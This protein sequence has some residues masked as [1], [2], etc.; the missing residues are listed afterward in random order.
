MADAEQS[1]IGVFPICEFQTE[2]CALWPPITHRQAPERAALRPYAPILQPPSP[3]IEPPPPPPGTFRI[4]ANS[5]GHG[6]IDPVGAIDVDEGEDQLFTITADSGYHIANVVVDGVSVGTGD[7]YTF[8]DVTEDHTITASFAADTLVDLFPSGIY[9]MSDSVSALSNPNVNGFKAWMQWQQVNPAPG[10][11]RWDAFDAYADAAAAAGKEFEFSIRIC[12]HYPQW[13]AFTPGIVQYTLV[14]DPRAK[15]I[16][17]WDPVAQ[18]LILQFIEDLC[19]HYEGR[20]TCIVMGGMGYKTE[21]YMPDPTTTTPPIA[22]SIDDYAAEWLAAAELIV[23]TYAANLDRTRFIVAGGVVIKPST[24]GEFA[25]L[26]LL[27]YGM[28]N[29]PE[30]FGAMQWGLNAQSST[31]FFMNEWIQ[32]FGPGRSTGFQ[33]TGS[34]D[35]IT[36][37]DTKGTLREC[38]QRAVDLGADWVEVYPTDCNNPAE[39]ATLAEFNALLKANAAV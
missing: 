3:V 4:S 8:T 24:V 20:V 28:N 11:Y 31:S 1:I 18:P 37:G 6:S 13:V 23:D 10:V 26:D 22:L 5:I 30:K 39:Q 21:C 29:Y 14:E 16:L 7:T 33:M 17:P 36:G 35:G 27:A 25:M 9:E 32:T 15:M 12:S 38:L 2:I 34:T 19:I